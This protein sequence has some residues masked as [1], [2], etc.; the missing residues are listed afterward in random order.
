MTGMAK[1]AVQTTVRL[2]PTDYEAAKEAAQ[3]EGI[4]L[5]EW[6]ARAIKERLSAGEG[7]R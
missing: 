4:S 5:N 3:R 1:P 2:E 7:R 6:I